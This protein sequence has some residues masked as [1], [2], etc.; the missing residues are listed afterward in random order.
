MERGSWLPL[1]VPL[2]SPHKLTCLSDE[3]VQSLLLLQALPITGTGPTLLQPILVGSGAPGLP[4]LSAG[5]WGGAYGDP[6]PLCC[7]LVTLSLQTNSRGQSWGWNGTGWLQIDRME[8]YWIVVWGKKNT[9]I[10]NIV[11]FLLSHY[12]VCQLMS[13]T[14]CPSDATACTFCTFSYMILTRFAAMTRPGS[15]N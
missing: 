5:V 6:T 14:K 11:F 15:R 9:E 10:D 4:R 7:L 8:Y 12:F 1:L 3:W 13:R 2:S